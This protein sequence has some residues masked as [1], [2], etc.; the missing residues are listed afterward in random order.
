MEHMPHALK[1]LEHFLNSLLS[2]KE[3]GPALITAV[4]ALTSAI[5]GALIGGRMTSRSAL[6][7]QKQA[8]ADQRQRNEE[9]ERRTVGGAL[10]AI[11]AE[12]RVLK[13]D[14]FDP[15]EKKLK[16]R[17][18]LQEYRLPSNRPPLEMTRTEQNRITVF[19]SNAHMLGRINDDYLRKQIIRVYGLIAVL[20][21]QLNEM[22][23][24]YKRWRSLPSGS[25]D[26]SSELLDKLR[27]MEGGLRNGLKD[28]QNDLGPVLDGI[29][30]YL[31]P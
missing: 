12:L 26:Q 30:K 22:S 27:D 6:R 4:A 9:A 10:R 24:D 15:L 29:D 20:I 7:A 2:S 1:H 21:D 16:G 28:L 5:I 25:G 31:N 11:A 17:E 19:Q 23:Q 3:Y 13:D 8:A 18:L 14:T